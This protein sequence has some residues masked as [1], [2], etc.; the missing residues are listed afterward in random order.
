MQKKHIS[1]EHN[2]NQRLI[3]LSKFDLMIRTVSF[4]NHPD[5]YCICSEKGLLN[6]LVLSHSL[7]N[8][9]CLEVHIFTNF[10]LVQQQIL[11]VLK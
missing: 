5:L 3:V 7:G 2:T 6:I 8:H 1:S 4:V 10:K 11:I 9:I